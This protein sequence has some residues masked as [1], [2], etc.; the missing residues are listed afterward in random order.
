MGNT[1]KKTSYFYYLV[2][3]V[4]KTVSQGL[5]NYSMTQINYPAKV[6]FKSA[7]PIINMLIGMYV[8]LCYVVLRYVMLSCV[9]IL[10]VLLCFIEKNCY[11]IEFCDFYMHFM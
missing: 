11:L 4:L 3:I 1:N 10:V 9:Y 7:T 8:M 5:T 2:L 6:L